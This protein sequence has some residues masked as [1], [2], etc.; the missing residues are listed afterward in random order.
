MFVSSDEVMIFGEA[1]RTQYSRKGK[2]TFHEDN[3]L[4][5]FWGTSDDKIDSIGII[6]YDTNCMSGPAANE[7]VRED[8]APDVIDETET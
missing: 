5:G 8:S 6:L 2:L 7:V 4:I 1:T 3:Q